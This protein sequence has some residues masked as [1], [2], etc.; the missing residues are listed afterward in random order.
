MY[1]DATIIDEPKVTTIW[2][3]IKAQSKKTGNKVLDSMVAYGT[4]R[5]EAELARMKVLGKCGWG[6]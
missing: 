4:R 2:N 6:Y 5:A 3:A 1:F